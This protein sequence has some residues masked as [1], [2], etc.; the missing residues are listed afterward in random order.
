L[1]LRRLIGRLLPAADCR[2]AKFELAKSN[3]ERERLTKALGDQRVEQEHLRISRD[4]HDGIGAEL[5]AMDWRL[6]NLAE[7][8]ASSQISEDVA[9]LRNRLEQGVSHL[10][11]VIRAL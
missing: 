9:E 8:H 7:E 1:T 4:I 10:Q 2:C 11:T 6:R 5:A 3:A